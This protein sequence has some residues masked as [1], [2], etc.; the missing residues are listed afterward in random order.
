MPRAA[1]GGSTL[2]SRRSIAYSS[3]AHSESPTRQP[4]PAATA[5]LARGEGLTMGI[6]A[7]TRLRLLG[8]SRQG[9]GEVT[10]RRLETLPDGTDQLLETIP[11]PSVDADPRGVGLHLVTHAQEEEDQDQSQGNAEQPEQNEKHG[12]APLL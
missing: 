12:F 7:A 11:A 4:I 9:M 6:T 5:R 10:H 3:R 1:S 2:G 8:R